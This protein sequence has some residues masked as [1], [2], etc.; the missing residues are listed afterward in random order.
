MSASMRLF[1]VVCGLRE[2]P[3]TTFA[4]VLERDGGAAENGGIE[5]FA[6]FLLSRLDKLRLSRR[7][8]NHGKP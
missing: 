1:G 4:A 7:D 5:R 3:R 2:S 8:K 6:G